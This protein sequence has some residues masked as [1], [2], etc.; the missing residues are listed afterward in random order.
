MIA[1][2]PNDL[3][4]QADSTL[5]LRKYD[6]Y[7]QILSRRQ[8]NTEAGLLLVHGQ[9]HDEA[10]VGISPVPAGIRL[11][12]VPDETG[13]VDLRH[14]KGIDAGRGSVKVAPVVQDK[15]LHRHLDIINGHGERVAGVGKDAVHID[16]GR[17]A[18]GVGRR[19]LVRCGIELRIA[20]AP[21]VSL[22][23]GVLSPLNA[24]IATEGGRGTSFVDYDRGG[25]L[26]DRLL[27]DSHSGEFCCE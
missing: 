27:T 8:A 19:R 17:G 25:R 15:E 26:G 6:A 5:G 20:R 14:V 9:R 21:V 4:L 13:V 7:R 10:N 23:V 3:E 1:V 16:P 12:A 22:V 11:V 24:G 18:R 2:G